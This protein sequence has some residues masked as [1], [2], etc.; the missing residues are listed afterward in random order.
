M[1]YFRINGLMVHV[2]LG[3]PKSKQPKPCAARI[4]ATHA[5]GTVQCCAISGFLCDWKLDD[6]STCDAPLCDEH[7][8]Q[9]AKDRH[10]C[11][12]HLERLRAVEPVLL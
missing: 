10:L 6:G 7:A 5:S 2:K 11:P 1:P 4:P 8:H 3:G 9:V 12:T